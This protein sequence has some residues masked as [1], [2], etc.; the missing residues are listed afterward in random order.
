ME[1]KEKGSNTAYGTSYVDIARFILGQCD[2]GVAFEYDD[3]T[4]IQIISKALS[5]T[6]EELLYYLSDATENMRQ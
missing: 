5:N 3:E 1:T 4:H 2:M 6:P